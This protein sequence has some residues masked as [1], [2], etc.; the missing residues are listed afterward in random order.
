MRD[1]LLFICKK[2]NSSY[3]VSY[4]LM[5]SAKFVVDA[6]HKHGV[7]AKIIEVVDNNDIDREV[8][9][10]RPSIVIIEALWVVPEKFK[11]L[12]R[13]HPHV[14]WFVRLHS[15]PAF[16]ANEGV[17]FEWLYGYR[18][19][20]RECG[21]VFIG[22]NNSEFAEALTALLGYPVQYMPNIYDREFHVAHRQPIAD[23]I[24]VGCFGS[25]RPLKNFMTQALA[26]VLYANKHQLRLRFH[27]N[28]DRIEQKGE[29]T[30]KNMEALFAGSGHQL[31]TH[32][33]CEHSEFIKLVRTMDVGMQV[34]LSETFNIVAADFVSQGIPIVVS[35]EIEWMP[36]LSKADPT[37][38]F[39]IVDEL[40]SV[41]CLSKVGLVHLNMFT[42]SMYNLR[43]I[44][45]WLSFIKN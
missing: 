32:P 3:G 12:T 43:A 8:N 27:I 7:D 11:I 28:G 24:N 44:R 37:S 42:L 21:N 30:L 5:N 22:A 20:Y 25:I 34:S 14:K 17:A 23:T 15:K 45:T 40:E 16:I 31:V 13:L 10:Y 35:S 1:K 36:C 18:D 26:A 4:G 6:L 39:D 29:N 19:V 33:W 41:L 9:K 2:R 38:I